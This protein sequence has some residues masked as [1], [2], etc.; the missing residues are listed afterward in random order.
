VC[1]GIAGFVREVDL[2]GGHLQAAIFYAGTIEEVQPLASAFVFGAACPGVDWGLRGLCA[3]LG[4]GG[5]CEDDIAVE[6]GRLD[7][8]GAGVAGRC[9][10]LPCGGEMN[11]EVVAG[12]GLV[13]STS[14]GFI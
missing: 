12:G 11:L 10:G 13:G 14:A 9:G 5:L 4:S 6:N 3:G 7:L 2:V 1:E 8:A